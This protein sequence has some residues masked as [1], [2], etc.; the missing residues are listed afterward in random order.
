[1][2]KL[3]IPCTQVHVPFNVAGLKKR[4][5]Q[6]K[7]YSHWD[8]ASREVGKARGL[9]SQG[10]GLEPGLAPKHNVRLE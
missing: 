7:R 6:I 8:R 3:S 9:V 1:L 10:P 4:S 5:S 2:N